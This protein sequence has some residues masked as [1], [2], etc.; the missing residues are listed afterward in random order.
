MTIIFQTHERHSPVA[1]LPTILLVDEEPGVRMTL[2]ANLELA[3]FVV[4]DAVGVL[5]AFELLSQ[6]RYE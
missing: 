4:S 1:K 6:S 3:C 5:E 2:A